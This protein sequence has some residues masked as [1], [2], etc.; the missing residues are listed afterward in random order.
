MSFVTSGIGKPWPGRSVVGCAMM[1]ESDDP[2]ISNQRM[3]SINEIHEWN[4]PINSLKLNQIN[5]N[6]IK[7][8]ARSSRIIKIKQSNQNQQAGDLEEALRRYSSALTYSPGDHLLHSN[9]SMALAKVGRWRESEEVSGCRAGLLVLLRF[10]IVNLIMKY[11]SAPFSC[12]EGSPLL[13]QCLTDTPD[14]TPVKG[15]VKQ[16]DFFLEWK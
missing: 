10:G 15:G 4:Q 2:L 6:Q 9:R 14:I 16:R 13:G 5:S 7:Q 3:K 11:F 8:T 1:G 12:D